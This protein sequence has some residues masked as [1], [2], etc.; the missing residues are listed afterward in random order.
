MQW[1]VFIDLEIELVLDIL[2]GR[3]QFD[4]QTNIRNLTVVG[5][6]EEQCQ[7]FDL[8]ISFSAKDV[9]TPVQLEMN[10]DVRNGVPDSEGNEHLLFLAIALLC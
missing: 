2:Q 5:T 8:T 3:I 7:D 9:F 1:F 10:Y 6:K 4:D